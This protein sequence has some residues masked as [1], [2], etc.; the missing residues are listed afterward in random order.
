[1]NSI[2]RFARNLDW[3]LLKY[4]TQIARHGGIGAAATSL[5]L[6]QP[7]VS[8][9]LRKLEEH[10]GAQLVIR[11]PKGVQLTS[12]GEAFSRECEQIL[13]RIEAMPVTARE[14]TGTVGGS[15]LVKTISH[16]ASAALDAG[17]LNFRE[18]YP[19]VELMLETA[20][21]ED[22]SQALVEGQLAV[23]VGFDDAQHPALQRTVLTYENMQIYCA[24]SHPLAE[25]VIDNPAD[26]AGEPFIAY[27]AGEPAALK[28]F[29]ERHRLGEHVVGFANTVHD[30]AWLISLGVG[31]GMLPEPAANA[32]GQDIVP[33]LGRAMMPRLAI[34]L[35]WR[36][37][38]QDRASQ[39]LVEA[40]IE[41]IDAR[42]P[43]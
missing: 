22:I 15:V 10:V 5:N 7:S 32:L 41:Q 25:R 23:G 14:L 8:A 38:L 34:D 28:A 42:V 26:L 35:F 19:D 43:Q 13:S 12:V 4:F 21:W 37:D 11:S 29:R 1:M 2:G 16:V 39:L 3:N 9:A 6:S 31:I 17:L 27:S 40:I 36:S 24:R 20:P 33:I 18:R 30:A